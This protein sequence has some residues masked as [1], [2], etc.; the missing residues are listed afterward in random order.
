VKNC[1][2]L[3]FGRAIDNKALQNHGKMRTTKIREEL[4]DYINKADDRFVQMVYAMMKVNQEEGLLT[5]AE[6][7]EVERR[8]ARHK[9][10]KIL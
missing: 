1:E 8:V 3:I 7:E 4:R 6:Q 10:I 2:I 9:Q 5:E